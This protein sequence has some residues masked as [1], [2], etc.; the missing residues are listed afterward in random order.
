MAHDWN[1]RYV[2]LPF[3]A[4]GFLGSRTR[5]SGRR[6]TRSMHITRMRPHNGECIRCGGSTGDEVECDTCFDCYELR[7][8]AP[9][10]YVT[11]EDE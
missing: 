6:V 7:D 8:C 5:K 4:P 10:Y 2:V 1:L 9:T 11:L 3:I